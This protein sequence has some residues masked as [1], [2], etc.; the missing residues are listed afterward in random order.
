MM[1]R[2]AGGEKKKKKEMKDKQRGRG[3]EIEAEGEIR[4]GEQWDETERRDERD[5]KRQSGRNP[6]KLY[7]SPESVTA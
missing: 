7:F 4:K 5:R 1:V 6:I 3:G 2:S